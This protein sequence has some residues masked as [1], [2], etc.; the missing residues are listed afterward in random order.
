MPVRFS[1]PP[2]S[3]VLLTA[4][5]IRRC[6]V[7][8]TALSLDCT[9]PCLSTPRFLPTRAFT[10]EIS[11]RGFVPYGHC[12]ETPFFGKG[13]WRAAT[14][15]PDVENDQTE[16][17][18]LWRGLVELRR[19]PDS[20]LLRGSAGAYTWIVTWASDSAEFRTRTEMLATSLGLYVFG[21]EGEHP[22]DKDEC[23]PDAEEIAELIERAEGNPDAILYGTFHTY[24]RDDA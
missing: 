3:T 2:A 23:S 7:T 4:D 15:R 20:E 10:T 22:I 19:L 24:P 8:A 14:I 18:E 6:S 11:V 12:H 21:I 1:T 13:T 9:H 17:R 5:M 16:R